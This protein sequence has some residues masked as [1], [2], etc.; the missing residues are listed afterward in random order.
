M[1]K[2]PEEANRENLELIH[3][4]KKA[5]DALIQAEKNRISTMINFKSTLIISHRFLKLR[6]M[7][8]LSEALRLKLRKKKSKAFIQRIKE[9]EAEEYKREMQERQEQEAHK[10]VR[11]N[12]E[13]PHLL[14]LLKYQ[15]LRKHSLVK[16][17]TLRSRFPL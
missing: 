17:R 14:H 9:A 8:Q 13:T 2:I 5:M 3:R 15:E 1:S 4:Q 7:G 12:K 11:K 10:K 6:K 16:L